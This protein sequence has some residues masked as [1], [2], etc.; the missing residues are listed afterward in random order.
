MLRGTGEQPRPAA[1]RQ[2]PDQAAALV[3]T[4]D[5]VLHALARGRVET[6]VDEQAERGLLDV[7]AHAGGCLAGGGRRED[8]NL[9][10]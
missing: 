8:R 6:T 7:L 1:R 9:G 4:I 2:S 5:V 10:G 3:A